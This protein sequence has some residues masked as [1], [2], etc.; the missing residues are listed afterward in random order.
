MRRNKRP[1]DGATTTSSPPSGG[2]SSTVFP[3]FRSL[4][5][6]VF[7]SFRGKDTRKIIV[8]P[9]YTYLVQLGIHTYRDDTTLHKG[10]RI[11]PSLMMAVAESQIAV[12]VFSENYG[13]SS[14]CLQELEYIM[15]CNKEGK[16]IV[17]PIFYGVVP[18]DVREQTGKFGEG[19]AKQALENSVND[20][21]CR[22][23]LKAAGM[24]SGW[25]L[26]HMAS[27]HES[28][29]TSEIAKTIFHGLRLTSNANEDPVGIDTRM[30]EFEPYLKLG[31]SDVHMIGIWGLRGG[32]KT[33]VA[34]YVYKEISDKFDGCCF[35]ENI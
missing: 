18:S 19:F 2:S 30:Q 24:I 12:I 8:D 28:A 29:I 34:S 4:D 31:S 14:S 1:Y 33:T 21:S 9:L 20:E 11:H 25:E 15:E 5:Y 22:K 3:S 16:L 17:I 32:G 10:K 26:K 35:L 23:A 6:D 7:L 13:D 27:G